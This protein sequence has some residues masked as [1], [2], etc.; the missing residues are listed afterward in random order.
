[1]IRFITSLFVTTAFVASSPTAY[2]GQNQISFITSAD[3]QRTEIS[4]ADLILATQSCAQSMF[5]RLFAV[6]KTVCETSTD[7]SL[8]NQQL[9]IVR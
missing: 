6:S 8:N 2:A 5:Q 9:Y 4:Y 7:P 1:M 3:Q